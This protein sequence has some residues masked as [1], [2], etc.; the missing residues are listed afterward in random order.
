M[1]GPPLAELRSVIAAD[2]YHTGR[3]QSSGAARLN[4]VRC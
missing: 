4:A 1:A 3:H 2:G